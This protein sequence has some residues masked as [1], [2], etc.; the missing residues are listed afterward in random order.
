V[1]LKEIQ[2]LLEGTIWI[3]WE[4]SRFSMKEIWAKK[5]HGSFCNSNFSSLRFCLLFGIQ[6]YEAKVRLAGLQEAWDHSATVVLRQ[7]RQFSTKNKASMCSSLH[8]CIIA[9]ARALPW[10]SHFGIY[11]KVRNEHLEVLS[12]PKADLPSAAPGAA[13]STNSPLKVEGQRRLYPICY[14]LDVGRL[15]AQTSQ[16]E[17]LIGSMAIPRFSKSNIRFKLPTFVKLQAHESYQP[18]TILVSCTFLISDQIDKNSQS[19]LMALTK[20]HPKPRQHP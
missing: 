16:P 7:G 1:A 18:S 17:V 11:A 15:N 13:K 4:N 3:L 10:F 14:S 12:P 19:I 8:H 2:D 6:K 5:S 9:R 20:F